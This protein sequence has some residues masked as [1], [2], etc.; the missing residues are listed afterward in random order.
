MMTIRTDRMLRNVATRKPKEMFVVESR[1]ITPSGKTIRQIVIF[2][3]HPAS[4]RLLTS[5][6]APR[7]QNDFVYPAFAILLVLVALLGTV[8]LW[9]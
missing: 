4:L 7:R 5:C 3:R 1:D 9:F 6:L 8:W 2:D